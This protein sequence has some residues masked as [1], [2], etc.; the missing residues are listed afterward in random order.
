MFRV[1]RDENVSA[2]VHA[3]A[4]TFFERDDGQAIEEV[5]EDLLALLRPFV[6]RSRCGSGSKA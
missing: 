4:G 1:G 3:G 6:R 2:D 5:I